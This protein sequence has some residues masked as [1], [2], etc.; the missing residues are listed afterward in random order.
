MNTLQ[1]SPSDQG[2]GAE[3]V[4]LTLFRALRARGHNGALAVGHKRSDDPDVVEIPRLQP[5][6]PW[7]RPW[8][9]LHGR[10]EPLQGRV[11]G[12]GRARTLLRVLAG[13]WPGIERAAGR[14]DFNFP[15][16]RRLLTLLPARPDIVHAHNL[17]GGYFDLRVLPRVSHQV[18][19]ILN[20]HDAWLLTGHCAHFFNCS[21]WKTGCGNC[22][23]L[24]IYPPIPRDATRYNWQRKRSIYKH[25]RLYVA[26]PSQWLMDQVQQS[27]LH[28]I[29]YRVIP[30]AIDLDVF[31]PGDQARA[32]A[33]LGLA[34]DSSIVLFAA[35]GA[36]RNIFKD[37]ATVE[38]AIRC[39]A[40][41]SPA[42]KITLLVLGDEAPEEAFGS[43]RVV[44]VPFERDQKRVA[45]FYQAAD[46]YVHAAKAEVCPKTII[47][48]LACGTPVVAT[49]VGGISEQIEDGR[50]GYL[51]PPR[52]AE[53]MATRVETL[54][55]DND[56]R[57][58]VSLAG[59]E[60]AQRRFGLDRQVDAFLSWYG[61]IIESWKEAGW[62][63]HSSPQ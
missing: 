4:A 30:N 3:G 43:A 22:P 44:T 1:I 29:E 58:R 9:A 34:P 15:G 57:R 25:S 50:T 24:T 51:V 7:A 36:R 32:R 41:R 42:V 60:E 8:W 20:L 38:A 10:L 46:V 6:V 49:A 23:D 40:Q 61:E 55:S 59:A 37:Y 31:K 12:V 16:S 53:A 13:G 14:E 56:L 39:I 52:D 45:L 54:L 48:A 21:R 62:Y 19:L 18:P 5:F 28:G 63:E 35:N 26:S 17:H 47:E 27:M 33:Q 2:G 11:R